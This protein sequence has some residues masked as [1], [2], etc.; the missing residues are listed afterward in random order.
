MSLIHLEDLKEMR[1]A[2]GIDARVI[3]GETMTV[4]HV[5]LKAGAVLPE[6]AHVHEQIVNLLEGEMLLVVDGQEFHMRGGDVMLLSPNVVHS[7]RTLTD[8][9]IV[10]AFHPVR[11]EFRHGDFAGYATERRS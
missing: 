5:R 10:D 3:T 6:H 1:I 2:E 8:C 9:R 7:G 11:E 4:L